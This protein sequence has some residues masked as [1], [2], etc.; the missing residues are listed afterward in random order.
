M[1]VVRQP[2][3]GTR[4]PSVLGID[5]GTASLKV[6]QAYKQGGKAVLETYGSL[7]L[8]PYG[9]VEVGR[10]TRLSL[11]QAV[12]ALKDLFREAN[13]T[14]KECA[15]AIPLSASLVSFMQL[16]AVAESELSTMVPTEARK[17]IPVPI[18]EVELDWM[19]VP[20]A[21]R[22]E[23]GMANEREGKAFGESYERERRSASGE[24]GAAEGSRVRRVGVLAVAIHK[25]ALALYRAIAREAALNVHFVEVEIFSAVRSVLRQGIAVG[26]VVDVG[27]HATK[28]YLVESGIVKGTHSINRGAQHI[29]EAL[30]RALGIS[31]PEAEELKRSGSLRERMG[32][33]A[34][35]ELVPTQIDFIFAEMRRLLIQYQHRSGRVVSHAIF[36]GGGAL[37]PGFLDRARDALPTDVSLG[38]PFEKLEAPAFLEAVLMEAGPEFAVATGLVLRALAEQ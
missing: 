21:P 5:F 38:N 34:L 17:Y 29:S 30:S 12:A 9:G 16:P 26:L 7:A 4:G 28:M 13:V 11:E 23:E 6:V 37:L 19:I 18:S 8:G 25:E 20:E 33:R 14:T 31:L 10:A 24:S 15:V 27:A 2:V 36:T 22:E 3:L 35:E 32:E 1:R